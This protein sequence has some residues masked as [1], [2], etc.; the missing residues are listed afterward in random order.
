MA[1]SLVASVLLS[2]FED[3]GQN[4]VPASYLAGVPYVFDAG[5]TTDAAS[6]VVST[7]L[8]INNGGTVNTGYTRQYSGHSV[9]YSTGRGLDMGWVPDGKAV[10]LTPFFVALGF[11]Q[12]V[13]P[14]SGSYTLTLAGVGTAS[15]T[16]IGTAPVITTPTIRV[17]H[18]APLDR[19]PSKLLQ[20]DF[21]GTY[22]SGGLDLT[23]GQIGLVGVLF[24]ECADNATYRFTWSA[25]KLRAW[26]SAGE[27]SG[28][29]VL[30]T[31]LLAF[32]MIS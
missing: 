19:Q 10:Y 21:T 25:S 1:L 32:G 20:L 24:A 7:T 30:S 14:T 18:P 2:G 5:W 9:P 8:S 22:P 27:A 23:E 4:I 12:V 16:V 11:W 28:S 31:Q 6:Q 3:P 17:L 29:V 15:V 26:T 13:F